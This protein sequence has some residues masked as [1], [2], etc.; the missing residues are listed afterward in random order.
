MIAPSGV[1]ALVDAG[2]VTGTNVSSAQTVLLER[3]RMGGTSA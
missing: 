2:I 1:D 3:A